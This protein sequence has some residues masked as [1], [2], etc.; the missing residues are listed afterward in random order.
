V[1]LDES[2][3]GETPT[4][5]KFDIEGAEPE[6]LAGGRR[7]IQCRMPVLAISSYHLQNHLWQLP[8]SVAAMSGDYR[9]FLRPHGFEGWDLVCY[10]VPGGRLIEDK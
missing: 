3:Q 8:L 7:T 1:A 4:I 10:A 2:L 9:Y 6:A 5:V